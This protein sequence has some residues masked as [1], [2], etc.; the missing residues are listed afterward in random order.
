LFGSRRPDA[1]VDRV[2]ARAAQDQRVAG[3]H[4]RIVADGGGVRDRGCD[5]PIGLT[6]MEGP[7]VCPVDVRPSNSRS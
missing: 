6:A 1:D 3:V 4:L 5:G 2:G 7:Q